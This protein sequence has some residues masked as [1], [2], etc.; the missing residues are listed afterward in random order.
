MG[1]VD[2]KRN[3]SWYLGL[4]FPHSCH[5]LSPVRDSGHVTITELGMGWS[6]PDELSCDGNALEF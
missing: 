6:W 4:F 2:R 3:R 5:S 1:A